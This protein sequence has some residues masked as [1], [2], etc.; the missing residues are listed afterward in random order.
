MEETIIQLKQ[1]Q[2]KAINSLKSGQVL[3]HQVGS[4]KSIT[5]L[6][7]AI[8]RTP[9]DT[10]P[11][12]V[13]ITTAKK[14]DSNEWLEDYHKLV[15]S[16]LSPNNARISVFSWNNITTIASHTK[17]ALERLYSPHTVFIFDEAKNSNP[18]GKWG[19]AYI[20]LAKLYTNLT[21]S[22]TPA[23]NYLQYANYL[24]ANNLYRNI[25]H[26]KQEHVI[27]DRYA[28]YPKI[29]SYTNLNKL[30][31]NIN[32]ILYT[33]DTTQSTKRQKHFLS[34]QI[35]Q[36]TQ[37]RIKRTRVLQPSDIIPNSDRPDPEILDNPTSLLNALRLN[38]NAKMKC[39][40]FLQFL[41]HLPPLKR[42]K[43]IIVFY[44]YRHE[45]IEIQNIAKKLDYNL[46]QL[47]G[48]RHDTITE[49][50]QNTL[51]AVQYT[52]GAEAWNSPFS[53]ITIFYSLNYSHRT[54][55]QA[56]G[57]MDRQNNP[58]TVLDYYYIVASNSL[59]VASNS[60]NTKTK[61]TPDQVIYQTITQKKKV[62]D[63]LILKE[64]NI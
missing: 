59:D 3:T 34:Y 13:I 36:R 28:K 20:K 32:Q 11:N 31:R 27:Y 24:I 50:D 23:D 53:D 57:R 63:E 9:K 26:F 14:R 16:H 48:D 8:Q 25:T 56:E 49:T 46:K 1:H 44:N 40:T 60:S 64:L 47:N 39:D 42:L 61:K 58:A 62:N 37:D 43:P 41:K 30:K 4:G 29:K 19:K 55:E 45:L 18:Q 12:I 52:S 33:E 6:M 21:L 17:Q 2:K 5:A 10:Q 22:A 35:D 7:W 51:Y 15:K 38:Q 54:M